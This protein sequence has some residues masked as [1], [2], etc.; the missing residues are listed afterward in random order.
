MA[1][2]FKLEAS[3]AAKVGSILVHVEE[4]LSDDGHTFDWAT[5]RT[6]LAQ[7]DVQAWLASLRQIALVPKKRK[8]P[9]E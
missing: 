8:E 4:G 6:L 7:A 9:T 3:L 1:D 5:A 2:P